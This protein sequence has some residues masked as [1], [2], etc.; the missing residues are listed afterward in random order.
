MANDEDNL[1]EDCD[2]YTVTLADVIDDENSLIEQA[3]AV[4][5]FIYLFIITSYFL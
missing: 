1:N 3:N 4:I 2:N 5:L